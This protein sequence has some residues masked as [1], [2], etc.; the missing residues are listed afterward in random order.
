M[1]ISYI[2]LLF[3]WK[4]EIACEIKEDLQALSEHRKWQ[5]QPYKDRAKLGTDKA[6]MSSKPVVLLLNGA[7]NLSRESSGVKQTWNIKRPQLQQSIPPVYDLNIIFLGCADKWFDKGSIT[8]RLKRHTVW[9]SGEGIHR[10]YRNINN[11][12]LHY[13][14]SNFFSPPTF[15]L[16]SQKTSQDFIL[17]YLQYCKRCLSYQRLLCQKGGKLQQVCPLHAS[18][19]A[20]IKRTLLLTAI[21]SSPLA[22]PCPSWPAKKTQTCNIGKFGLDSLLT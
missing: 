14:V 21:C 5:V 22:S 2:C 4:T 16:F 1:V 11:L 10:I 12:Q 9:L 15:S 7:V 8:S 17:W 13:Q 18:I 6:F 20:V 19:F 3:P